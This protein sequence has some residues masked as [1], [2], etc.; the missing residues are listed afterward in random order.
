MRPA[1]EVIRLLRLKGLLRWGDE[2]GEAGAKLGDDVAGGVERTEDFTDGVV[3]K[4]PVQG[5]S[6]FRALKRALG[7]AGEGRQWHHI[8]EQSKI[9]QFGAE[10]IQ[11]VDNVIALPKPVHETISGFYS[12]KVAGLTGDKTVRQWLEGKPFQFQ[13]EFGRETIKNFIR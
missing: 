2:A 9:G 3:V 11:N 7:P 6:S 1:D 13:Y 8:V 4:A 12:S 10:S 5:F